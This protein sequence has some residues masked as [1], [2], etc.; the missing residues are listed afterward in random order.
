MARQDNT[1]GQRKKDPWGWLA[2]NKWTGISV[3]VAAVGVVLGLVFSQGGGSTS[4]IQDHSNC[5]NAGNGNSG[6]CTDSS[7]GSSGSPGQ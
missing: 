1:A 3:L 5:S 6:N 2:S 7:T 4:N